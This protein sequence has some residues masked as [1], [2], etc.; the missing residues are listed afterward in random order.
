MS[1]QGADSGLIPE[2]RNSKR[3]LTRR[4]LAKFQAEVLLA[5]IEPMLTEAFA[6]LRK[7]VR[8]GSI[9]HIELAMQISGLVNSAKGPSVIT[10]VYAKAESRSESSSTIDTTVVT[11]FE[12]L[13]RKLDA[14]DAAAKQGEIIEITIED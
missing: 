11:S 1:A 4:N 13:A 14:R 3:R 5:Q 2:A 8:A 9:K 6:A 10:N 12:S 7:G